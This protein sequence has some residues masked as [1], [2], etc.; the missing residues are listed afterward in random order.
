M[1]DFHFASDVGAESTGVGTKVKELLELEGLSGVTLTREQETVL[2]RHM[3]ATGLAAGEA[4]KAL[5][6]IQPRKP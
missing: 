2:L 3:K 1:K 4:L 6:L 5:G